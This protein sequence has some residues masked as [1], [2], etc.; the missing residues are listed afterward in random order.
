MS[1]IFKNIGQQLDETIQIYLLWLGVDH[2]HLYIDAHPDYSLDEIANKII[3]SSEQEIL[4]ISLNLT[5]M[6]KRFGRKIIS[7]KLLVNQ[8]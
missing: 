4:N 3:E 5:K 7:Q 8:L 2:V 1:D 6:A